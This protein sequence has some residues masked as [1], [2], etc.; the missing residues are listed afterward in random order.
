MTWI[1]PI[2]NQDYYAV[3][4]SSVKFEQVNGYAEMDEQA[5]SLAIQQ[6]GYLGYES[7]SNQNR[8]I[9]ISYW[10]SLEAIDR[11]AEN[12]VHRLAKSQAK[13]WYKRYLSQICVVQR[14]MHFEQ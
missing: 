7:V 9:F 1:K 2:P 11:W 4:F 14:S 6:P 8:S 5:M 12:S 10:E 13:N 3:I